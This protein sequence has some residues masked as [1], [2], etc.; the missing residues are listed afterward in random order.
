MLNN[1]AEEISKDAL[2]AAFKSRDTRFDGQV[3]VG[4]SSTGIYCRPVCTARLPKY[5]NCAFFHSPAE[6]EAAGYR[7]CMICRPETAPGLSAVDARSSLA[8]RAAEYLREHCASGES[9]EVLAGKLGYTTRHLRRVFVDELHVTPV[10]YLQT[11][12][13]LLAKSLLTDTTLP[14]ARVAE[15]AGFG[16]TRRMDD[17]FK[18]RYHLTPSDLRKRKNAKG[19]GAKAEER[20]E[21]E[22][23]ALCSDKNREATTYP[24]ASEKAAAHP[25]ES[26]DA[27]MRDGITVRLSYRPPYRFAEVLAFF[28]DRA[29]AGVEVVG[30]GFYARTVRIPLENGSMACGWIRVE[31]DNAKNMLRITMSESL[32]PAISHVLARVRRQFDIDCNPQVIDESLA[33]LGDVAPRARVLGTRLPGCFEPFETACRAVLGQQVSVKAANKLAARIIDVHGIEVDTGIEE[34]NRAWPTPHELLELCRETP[35]EESFGT[36]GVIKTRSRTIERIARMLVSGELNLED[37]AHAPEQMQTLLAVKG[38]GPWTAN[39]VAMRTMSYPDAFLETDAGI[40]HAL[41]D[42]TPKQ[43]LAA[44]ESWRPWRSYAVIA[45]W[46]S[47]AADNQQ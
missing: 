26:T 12:R 32:L 17:L 40:A 29:L 38:I 33:S 7:P 23:T 11:C 46:N 45:L 27:I 10:Q 8:R 42:L 36:L 14:V 44:A 20:R 9:L 34:L 30:D 35:L 37:T 25:G 2:Y 4:V 16:S 24:G 43:R 19:K 18:K 28:R 1:R 39:Y 41:P 22:K 13:L 47:L 6:A 21:R 31:N 15:A 3:F 5:E